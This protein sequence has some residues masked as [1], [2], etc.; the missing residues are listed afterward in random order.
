MSGIFFC[1]SESYYF[2]PM[3]DSDAYNRAVDPD[4]S[5]FN[6]A[7]LNT[8]NFSRYYHLDELKTLFEPLNTEFNL[9]IISQNIRSLPKNF[10]EFYWDL[11]IF[12]FQII[13]L[14]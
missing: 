7:N 9:E 4:S 8:G 12:K 13:S 14:N 3:S 2:D 1:E 11:E 5:F 6:S 10:D